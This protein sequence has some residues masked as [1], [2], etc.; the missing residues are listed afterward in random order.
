M[1]VMAEVWATTL[2][3]AHSRCATLTFGVRR[4]NLVLG[5][6][7]FR[8][9]LPQNIWR[10]HRPNEHDVGAIQNFCFDS[11]VFTQITFWVQCEYCLFFILTTLS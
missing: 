10:N 8:G 4:A 3:T 5:D 7:E 9:L 2:L 6:R 1:A 11:G